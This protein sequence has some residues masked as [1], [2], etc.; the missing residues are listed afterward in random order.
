[1]RR[2]IEDRHA[3]FQTLHIELGFAQYTEKRQ[4]Q[5][6][7]PVLEDLCGVGARINAHADGCQLATPAGYA[8]QGHEFGMA[9]GSGLP[10]KGRTAHRHQDGVGEHHHASQIK[11]MHAA[12][13]VQHDMGDT[14]GHAQDVLLVDHP[15]SDGGEGCITPAQP[16]PGGLLSVYIAQH[17][18]AAIAGAPGSQMRGDSAFSTAPFAINHGD[19]RHEYSRKDP[20][21]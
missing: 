17:H 19:H 1:M 9:G 8:R 16:S 10:V 6:V 3:A 14:C 15:G 21:R 13:C 11:A 12:R 5:I 4:L 20:K 18:G 7:G 2:Q